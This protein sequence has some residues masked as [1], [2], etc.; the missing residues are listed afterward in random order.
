MRSGDQAFLY[1]LFSLQI[2]ALCYFF[3][4][5]VLSFTLKSW[6]KGTTYKSLFF[7]MFL[8]GV[9][10]YWAYHTVEILKED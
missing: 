1:L 8:I 3:V 2:I 5:L 9:I 7:K 6:R 4:T 10:S